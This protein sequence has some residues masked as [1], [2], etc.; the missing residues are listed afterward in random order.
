M[1]ICKGMN[2]A[3]LMQSRKKKECENMG[4]KV[5]LPMQNLQ[6]EKNHGGKSVGGDPVASFSRKRETVNGYD[7]DHNAYYL[8]R[9]MYIISD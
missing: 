7:D 6:L 9:F 5:N 4:Q 1:Y 3:V 8:H 2:G